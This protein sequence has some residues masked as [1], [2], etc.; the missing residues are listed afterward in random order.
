MSLL[1]MKTATS[2]LLAKL[3]SS[4]TY[5]YHDLWEEVGDPRIADYP[6]MKGGPWTTLLI[7]S[8]YLYIVLILGP[9]AMKSRKALDLKQ[10]ILVYNVLMVLAN[11]WF[12]LEG[13]VLTNASLDTW[14]CQL[15][16]KNSRKPRDVRKLLIGWLFYCSK[17][18]EL[19]DTL[20]FILRKKWGQVS[21]LHVVHHSAVPVLIWIGLKLSPGGM[22]GLFPLLNSFV[23]TLMYTYYALSTLGP[24]L[25]PYLWWKRYLTTVQMIQFV[26]VMVHSLQ[27]LFLPSCDFPKILLYLSVFN[28]L[29]FL[30]LFYSFYRNTYFRKI[31]SN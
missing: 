28:A 24:R 6:L 18:V 26:I 27:V 11:G 25:Q 19:C 17:L 22:M 29:L 21:T 13:M 14:G 7:V 16:D 2:P 4:V 23:H 20:F 5:L 9:R 10:T 1:N 31:K 30:L 3:F 15:V 12:F 8:L